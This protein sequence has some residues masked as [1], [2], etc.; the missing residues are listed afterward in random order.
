VPRTKKAAGATVDRRN[1]RRADLTPIQGARIDSPEGLTDEAAAL[2]DAYWSDTVA[3]VATVVDRGLLLRWIT[4]YDRYLRTV[5]EADKDPVTTGSQG[6]PI[7]NPLY[8]I[9]YRALE[10]AERCERQLGIGPLHRSALGIA[11]ITERRSLAD[12]NARYGGADGD[13]DRIEAEA[14]PDPRAVEAAG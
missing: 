1:G 8:K 14:R 5:A 12:M 10:A 3:T 4:E 6:Q 7:Q 2:W 13:G 11:V 9:A